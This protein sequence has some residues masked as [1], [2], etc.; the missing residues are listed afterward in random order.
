[1]N[2]IV[3]GQQLHVPTLVIIV[4]ALPPLETAVVVPTLS[5]TATPTTNPGPQIS[6]G[7][8]SLTITTQLVN[9]QP[10]RDPTT[11]Q[12]IADVTVSADAQGLSFTLGSNTATAAGVTFN[13]KRTAPTVFSGSWGRGG[14]AT[15]TVTGINQASVSATAP[16]PPS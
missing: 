1:V 10:A 13:F 5:P 15:L 7:R 8:W 12:A 4:T 2:H 6:S 3:A 14:V 11:I 9:C 16:C